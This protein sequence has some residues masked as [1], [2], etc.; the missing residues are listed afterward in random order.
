MADLDSL[1]ACD[2]CGAKVPAPDGHENGKFLC[3]AC[4][5]LTQSAAPATKREDSPRRCAFCDRIVARKDC[6]RNRYGEYVCLEC[7]K[8]GLRWSSRRRFVK[9]AKKLLRYA[10]IGLIG[11]SVAAVYVWFIIKVIAFVAQAPPPA[12]D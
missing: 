12:N 6:H 3:P 5:A 2:S 11:V 8:K 10:L 7:Q 4:H 1:K 9:V